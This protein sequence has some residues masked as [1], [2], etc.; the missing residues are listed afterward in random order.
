MSDEPP[1]YQ[2]TRGLAVVIVYAVLTVVGVAL[3]TEPSQVPVNDTY[4]NI[5]TATGQSAAT[6]P[7]I[8]LYAFLGA[9]AYAFTSIIAK[10]ERG[11]TGVLR[12]GLRALAALPLAA[13]VFL[14]A[15]T[16]GVSAADGR[17]LAGV[18]FLVGLYVSVALKSLGGLA[19]RLLGL[20][21][22]ESNSAE[23]SDGQETD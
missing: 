6:P 9:M 2:T 4:M 7:A 15:G 11:T 17:V 16:L 5:S 20:S 21:A 8:Y 10:F 19:E 12:V 22:S 23:Q 3:S 14:L 13:G 18:A 1:W